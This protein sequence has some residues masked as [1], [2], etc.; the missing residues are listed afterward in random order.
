MPSNSRFS[1][2]MDF[3]T[4]ILEVRIRDLSG[5][6]VQKF[7]DR[8]MIM[9]SAKVILASLISGDGATTSPITKIA[10]GNSLVPP[11]PDDNAIG[12]V[13]TTSLIAGANM[14][15]STYLAHLKSIAGHTY[16]SAG[17]VQ[18]TWELGYGEANGLAISEYGL[19][20]TDNTLF[21]RKTRGVVTKGSDL[22]IDGAW[23]IIF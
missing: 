6:I 12:G 17:R 3:P 8:N 16:P 10:L 1:E 15:G 5:R 2:T 23:T 13:L 22:A 7:T 19:V 4:G 11:T 21:S 9:L 20:S 18:F 14:D